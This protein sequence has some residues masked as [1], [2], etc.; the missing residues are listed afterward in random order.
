MKGGLRYLAS[1]EMVW[2]KIGFA[3]SD[4]RRLDSLAMVLLKEKLRP[5]KAVRVCAALTAGRYSLAWL[6]SQ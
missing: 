4:N 1:R 2:F 3:Q 6:A 5:W